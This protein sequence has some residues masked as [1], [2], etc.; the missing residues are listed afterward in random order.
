MSNNQKYCEPSIARV[1]SEHVSAATPISRPPPFS[2]E[3]HCIS[4]HACKHYDDSDPC[5]SVE[6][7]TH[8]I[9]HYHTAL[10]TCL[11]VVHKR[12]KVCG[13]TFT[14]GESIKGVKRNPSDKMWRCGSI[15]TLVKGRR[16]LYAWVIQF[17]SFDKIHLTH[18]KWLSIPE[19]PCGNPLVVLLRSGGTLPNLSCTVDLTEI[20][21][22]RIAILH[23]NRQC[24]YPIRLTGIDTMRV[25]DV[26][27]TVFF[28]IINSPLVLTLNY[29]RI[30]YLFCVYIL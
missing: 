28:C 9:K 4:T 15:I 17:L 13:V 25:W 7:D 14:S 3:T 18:V 27:Q 19:Y 23:E 24:S 30:F 12:A 1:Y 11:W 8:M 10:D 26:L 16:S 5:L 22:S 20:D 6:L 29:S 2:L 21:P